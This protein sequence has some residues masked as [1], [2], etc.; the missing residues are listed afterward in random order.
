MMLQ[1]IHTRLAIVCIGALVLTSAQFSTA[2]EYRVLR[3]FTGSTS[4][5]A[6]PWGSLIRSGSTLYG[7][8]SQG[9]SYNNGTVFRMNADGTAFQLMHSFV[10]AAND[11]QN[12][13]GSLLLSGSTL[14]GMAT[15]AGSSYGGTLFRIRTDSTGF[16]VRRQFSVS[17]G[18]WPWDSLMQS[19]T[20]FYGM[21]TYGGNSSDWDG[22]G[23]IFKF[24]DSTATFTLLHTFTGS[25]TDGGG[26]HGTLIQIGSSLYGTTEIGGS[27]NRGT[28]FKINP[29]G[30]GFQLLHS[31]IG[32]ANDGAL[33]HCV[34]LIS[35]DSALYGITFGGGSGGFGT[36]FKMN[37]DGTDFK[38][39]HSF[40]GGSNGRKPFGSLVLSGSTLYGMT[41]DENTGTNGTIFS[42]NTNGTDFQVLHRFTGTDGRDPGGSLLLSG[43]TLYGMTSAG[44][45]YGKGV[46]FALT[47]PEPATIVQLGLAAIMLGLAGIRCRCHSI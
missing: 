13:L 24:D 29:D 38:L 28:V 34:T 44:G 17:N 10:S 46:I 2:V 4:D 32:S 47:V 11:G 26:P 18:I 19:G 15:S 3:N 1:K 16:Q 5:G 45:S 25:T 8:T 14:Y 37:P 20:T 30:S 22:K 6:I 40:A 12:P 9:G 31:F 39:L 42:I 41:S 7:M 21:N 43:S 35:A 23:T 33:P 27:S 36:I